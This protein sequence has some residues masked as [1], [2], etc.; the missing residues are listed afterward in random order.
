MKMDELDPDAIAK[1]IIEAAMDVRRYYEANAPELADSG[2]REALHNAIAARIYIERA[3]LPPEAN[4][5]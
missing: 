3:A 1:G 4:R 2:F 5:E